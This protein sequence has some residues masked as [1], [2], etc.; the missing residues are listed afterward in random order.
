MVVGDVLVVLTR[1][2]CINL[3]NSQHSTDETDVVYVRVNLV[4][5]EQFYR[6]K[7]F[8]A[9]EASKREFRYRKKNIE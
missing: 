5:L 1:V 7:S 2:R 8:G 4:Q 3:H 6:R 9:L